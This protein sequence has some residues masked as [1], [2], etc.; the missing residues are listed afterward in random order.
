MTDE[1]KRKLLE[2]LKYHIIIPDEDERT[3]ETTAVAVQEP[4]AGEGQGDD[5]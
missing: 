1:A 2:I 3:E 5:L 4:A